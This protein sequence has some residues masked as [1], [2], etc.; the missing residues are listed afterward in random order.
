MLE[1]RKHA[2]TY[3]DLKCASVLP[4]PPS[5]LSDLE[6]LCQTHRGLRRRAEIVEKCIAELARLNRG[7]PRPGE[8]P[9]GPVR[10]SVEEALRDARHIV[11]DE[12]SA[13]YYRLQPG[14]KPVLFDGR[15]AQVYIE[16][17]GD[18]GD[19][20]ATQLE[21][22]LQEVGLA[23]NKCRLTWTFQGSPTRE[24]ATPTA[25][26]TRPTL[27]SP[28]KRRRFAS[29]AAPTAV[30]ASLRTPCGAPGCKRDY[31]AMVVR[32]VR[33]FEERK[34]RMPTR[35]P[36]DPD[37]EWSRL[38]SPDREW[39]H[40]DEWYHQAVLALGQVEGNR[41]NNTKNDQQAPASGCPPPKR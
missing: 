1:R 14:D 36:N 6:R 18:A 3:Q 10:A 30:G 33:D 39:C 20:Q 29:G 2:E 15:G 25:R 22:C 8:F 26:E 27:G 21:L 41:R 24:Q 5:N 11:A 35:R 38:A 19:D 7:D 12:S 31:A 32:A 16:D 40:R 13:K 37:D 9:R 4:N 28:G 17:D 23:W 34:G